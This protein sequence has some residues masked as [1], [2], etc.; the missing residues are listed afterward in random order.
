MEIG[1]KPLIHRTF[2]QT[3][4]YL[5]A[6]SLHPVHLA[7][8]IRAGYYSRDCASWAEGSLRTPTSDQ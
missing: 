2:S 8:T 1:N 6:F 4:N 7:L 5:F 3:S